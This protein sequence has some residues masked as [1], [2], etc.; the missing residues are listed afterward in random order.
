MET[1]ERK[2]LAEIYPTLEHEEIFITPKPHPSLEGKVRRYSVLILL[3]NKNETYQI[4]I[5]CCNPKDTF[6]R[7]VTPKMLEAKK[8]KLINHIT[9]NNKL[10]FTDDMEKTVDD[11]LITFEIESGYY[12]AKKRATTSPQFQGPQETRR[13]LAF[14]L[15]SILV[16]AQYSPDTLYSLLYR[17]TSVRSTN[18]ILAA[19]ASVQVVGEWAGVTTKEANS[20]IEDTKKDHKFDTDYIYD[21]THMDEPDHKDGRLTL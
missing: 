16:F 18:E 15:K 3:D 17:P 5:A 6:V 21:P 14:L 9:K 19:K 4:G 2:S 13:T 20:M 7:K 8:R 11:A 1:K 12:Q 10:P